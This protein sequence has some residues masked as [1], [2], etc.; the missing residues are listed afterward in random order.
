MGC[1]TRAT[2][3]K[4]ILEEG[5]EQGTINPTFKRQKKCQ[6]PEMEEKLFEWLEII[7]VWKLPVTKS[8]IQ[9]KAL[10]IY[11]KL[12][13]D[14]LAIISNENHTGS[15][16]SN[17]KVQ[18]EFTAS[19][20]W[21]DGLKKRHQIRS[22]K[23]VGESESSETKKY[24]DK[25]KEIADKISEFNPENVYYTDEAALFYKM[26]PSLT[27]CLPSEKNPHGTKQQKVRVTVIFCSNMT[28]THKL[29]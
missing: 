27:Y 8:V 10:E 5:I 1:C 25:L 20:G 15:E 29:P 9:T 18:K 6:Y 28:G 23:L 2:K 17:Q 12:K 11:F 26:L 14:S 7:R 4:S 16:Q 24:E 21:F 13:Q 19:D 3:R 22:C